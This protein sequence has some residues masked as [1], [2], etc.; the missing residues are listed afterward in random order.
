MFKKRQSIKHGMFA[1]IFFNDFP[2]KLL[3]SLALCLDTIQYSCTGSRGKVLILNLYDS[4]AEIVYLACNVPVRSPQVLLLNGVNATPVY[5]YCKVFVPWPL[6]VVVY[7]WLYVTVGHLHVLFD[8]SDQNKTPCLS[9]I[10][11]F[12]RHL[13]HKW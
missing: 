1:M 3:A 6:S 8:H 13:L 11:F 12:L 4:C 7:Y 5:R 10:M 9:I 2:W